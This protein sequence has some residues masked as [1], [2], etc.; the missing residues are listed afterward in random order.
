[1][2]GIPCDLLANPV[3]E[4]KCKRVH[5]TAFIAILLVR[6]SSAKSLE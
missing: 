3:S 6:D 2:P 1:L 4:H 5:G